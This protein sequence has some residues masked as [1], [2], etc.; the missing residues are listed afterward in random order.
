MTD[1]RIRYAASPALDDA[2]V[3]FKSGSLYSCRPE[4]G[5]QCG[6][7]LG[8]KW[9]FLNSATVIETHDPSQRMHYIVV[10]LSN[11]LRKNSAE[12]HE[13]LARAIHQLMKQL[14]PP[15]GEPSL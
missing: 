6:K 4:P 15:K 5:Y 3:Y 7:Y 10:V 13:N 2:A 9:N 12:E 14:H 8:N 1:I 11:V